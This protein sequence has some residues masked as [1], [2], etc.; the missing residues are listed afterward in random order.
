VIPRRAIVV[1]AGIG[2][3]A[4]AIALR[5]AGVDVRVFERA[6][7]IREVGAGISLWGNAIAALNRLGLADDVR[8]ASVSYRVGGLRAPDGSVLSAISDEE[9]RLF[10]SPVVLHRADLHE[11]LLSAVPTGTVH[12]DTACTGFS[13]RPAGV[14]VTLSGGRTEDADFLIGADGLNSVIRAG[15]HGHDEPRYAGCTA[16]RAVVDFGEP[17]R[18]T[19][20]WGRGQLFGQVPISRGRVYWYAGKRVPPGGRSANPN[21]ELADLYKGWHAPIEA[22]IAATPSAAILRNDLF[23]RPVLRRWGRERVTLLGDA[24]HPMTPFL[25]QGACQALE[26]A[27][28]LGHVLSGATDLAEALRRYEAHRIPRANTF[29]TRSRG[30]GQLALLRNRILV[31]LRNAALRRIPRA[32]QARHI[33]RM[34]DFKLPDP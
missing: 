7:V 16:W 30:T 6:A 5:R 3:L 22:L 24:A 26:D 2:G 19:E 29:V 8:S 9:A 28:V 27:V 18:A 23:D 10:D 4:A 17:V 21:E 15:L 14:T 11:V 20:T 25:G 32:A 1:G 34:I 13:Q 33:A 12:L 31:W